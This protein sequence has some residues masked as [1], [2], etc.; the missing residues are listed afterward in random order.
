MNLGWNIETYILLTG[1]IL[2]FVGCIYIL[3]FNWKQYGKLLI[4]SAVIGEILCYIFL[5]LSFYSFPYRLFPQVAPM[6]F[7]L[8]LTMFPFYVLLGV[9]YS[10]KAWG[11]KI[12]FYWCIVHI[13]M[14]GEILSENYTKVIKY[15][16]FWDAWDSYTWWWI[17]LLV[18]EWVGGMIVGAE[19]RK[20]LDIEVLRYGKIG[21][22]IIHFILIGTVFL[23][24]VYVGTLVTG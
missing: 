9:R 13:G 6:P 8:I 11:W 20:P 7:V 24:G 19:Y 16:R 18:F 21:W 14:L 17:Y 5:I 4:L 3:R 10:P 2:S 12:P 22:F 15:E 1:K 23:A